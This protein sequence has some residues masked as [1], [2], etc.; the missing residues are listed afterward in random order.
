MHRD[1][2]V[3]I[4]TVSRAGSG[5][6][7][8]SEASRASRRLPGS[9]RDGDVHAKAI[10]ALAEWRGRRQ[11]PGQPKLVAAAI[12]TLKTVGSRDLRVRAEKRA[13]EMS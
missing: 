12:E 7:A 4:P 8:T 2:S 3:R 1:F 6:G 11:Q 5:S 9:R 10:Y 13:D